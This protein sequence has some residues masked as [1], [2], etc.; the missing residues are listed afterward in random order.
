M[1][2]MLCIIMFGHV[3]SKK[4]EDLIYDQWLDSVSHICKQKLHRLIIEIK[5]M[6]YILGGGEGQHDFKVEIIC[7]QQS[8]CKR[9]GNNESKCIVF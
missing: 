1:F 6:D 8:I 5:P 7:F 9:K 4:K 2:A 3:F